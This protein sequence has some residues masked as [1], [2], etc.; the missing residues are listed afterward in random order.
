[1]W[2]QIIAALFAL[3]ALGTTAVTILS[4]RRRHTT[5][6]V[7]SLV[8]VA[9]GIVVWS[10]ADLLGVLAD[11]PEC[12]MLCK[13]AI[14][15]GVCVGAAATFCLFL[16]VT[17]RGWSLSRRTALLLAIE[18]V[19]TV[20]AAATMVGT[21]SSSGRRC[22]ARSGSRPPTTARCSGYT[23]YTATSC[24]PAARSG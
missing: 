15:P 23:P 6:A 22:G 21:T 4:W 17:D 13:A 10:V 24:S 12:A 2:Q 5:T 16:A 3:S 19:L 7:Y 11:T 8:F 14:F 1:M 20:T 18:P 9:A